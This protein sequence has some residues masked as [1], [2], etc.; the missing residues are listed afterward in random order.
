MKGFFGIIIVFVILSL[1]LIVSL[2]ENNFHNEL[3]K[4]TVFM[5]EAEQASKNRTIM[6]NN[7]DK[8]IEQKLDEQIFKKN[9]NI[10]L[11]LN[12]INEALEKYLLNKAK[13]TNIYTEVGPPTKEFLNNNSTAMIIENNGIIYAEYFFTGG[14]VKTNTIST[15]FGKN[16]ELF[17]KIPT[18][19]VAR[20]TNVFN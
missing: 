13:A 17:F 20:R 1:L 16:I 12:N 8:I 10:D 7:V 6:E 4:A 15:N 5:I 3:K 2:K 14:L 9:F 19:Y 18:D 11:L